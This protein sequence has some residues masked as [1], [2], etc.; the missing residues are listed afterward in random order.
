MGFPIIK[1]NAVAMKG[2]TE[3]DITP[4][5]RFGRERR[6]EVRF[7]EFMPLDA[8]QIWALDRVL[9]ADDMIRMIETEFG[10]LTPVK[11]ADPRAPASEYEFADG[12]RAG[13]IASVSRPFCLNCNRLRLTA[14]G[15]MRN[16]LFAT[17]ETN[18]RHL[19]DRDDQELELAG[20]IRSSVWQKWAGHEISRSTFAAPNRPMYSIGG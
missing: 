20:A 7:I 6:I 1:I 10:P 3:Q 4:L 15:K 13:F 17:D 16:C 19:L 5:I 12:Y 9:T 11:D 14:D 18:V 2:L 8:Q